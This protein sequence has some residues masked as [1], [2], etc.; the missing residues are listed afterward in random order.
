MQR[1]L[2]LSLYLNIYTFS[3]YCGHVLAWEPILQPL[4]LC[5]IIAPCIRVYRGDLYYV[6]LYLHTFINFLFISCMYPWSTIGY[7]LCHIIR[8]KQ[9]FCVWC[10]CAWSY[11]AVDS[12]WVRT[13]NKIHWRM[14]RGCQEM[15]FKGMQCILGLNNFW[16]GINH[17][18]NKS[19]A[20]DFSRF[21]CRSEFVL[22]G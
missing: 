13:L 15:L 14:M 21:L 2:L 5:Y 22:I 3:P 11:H 20:H 17:I 16:I 1:Q 9:L 10:W 19:N 8:L 12:L 18:I 7:D 6:C 4:Q